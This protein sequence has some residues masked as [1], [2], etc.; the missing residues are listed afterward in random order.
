M[1]FLDQFK[2]RLGGRTILFLRA[3]MLL[4]LSC[5]LISVFSSVAGSD[6]SLEILKDGIRRD[7]GFSVGAEAAV[8]D[9]K[10]W[11]LR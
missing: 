2:L 7:T 11:K 9:L 5:K 1:V 10:L 6:F 8:L 3:K 4:P